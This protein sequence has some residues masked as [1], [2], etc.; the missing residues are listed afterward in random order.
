MFNFDGN[1]LKNSN[2]QSFFGHY[3]LDKQKITKHE[4]TRPK[5]NVMKS[6]EYKLDT[7]KITV[8]FEDPENFLKN[9]L[10]SLVLPIN[11]GFTTLILKTSV[12]TRFV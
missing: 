4:I 1:F 7:S 12:F 3:V 11:Y 6:K 9:K 5:A 10:S 8:R 2:L